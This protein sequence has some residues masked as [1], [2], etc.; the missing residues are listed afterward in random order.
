M[1][2]HACAPFFNQCVREGRCTH[3]SLRGEAMEPLA[4]RCAETPNFTIL[5][6]HARCAGYTD[7]HFARLVNEFQAELTCKV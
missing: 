2:V 1:H 6:L 5:P 7:D 4:R 3:R